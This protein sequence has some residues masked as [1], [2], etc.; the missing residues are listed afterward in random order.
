MIWDNNLFT[1][2][3]M[4]L[5]LMASSL[6]DKRESMLL[7]YSTDFISFQSGQFPSH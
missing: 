1:G 2:I 4:T 3:R 6:G 7:E 5:F